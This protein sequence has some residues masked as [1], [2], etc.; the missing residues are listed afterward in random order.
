VL[1]VRTHGRTDPRRGGHLVCP[2][3]KG[4]TMP[5]SISCSTC[6][7]HMW[8]DP[9]TRLPIETRKCRNCRRSSPEYTHAPCVTC[10]GVATGTRCRKCDSLRRTVWA[11]DTKQG[12]RKERERIPG[13][14]RQQRRTLLHLWRTQ[15]RA[16]TYCAR[17]C[18]TIDHVIP[19]ARGGTNYEGN[20]APACGSCNSS[21]GARFISEWQYISSVFSAQPSRGS[22]LSSFTHRG[23]S[24]AV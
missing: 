13:I 19:L 21:K 22:R 20:L 7:G 10:G 18:E 11:S 5:R 3:H 1:G 17:P 12:R 9:K 8:F 14:S 16:C 15:Q 23:Q 24:A 4:D 6:G 2:Q